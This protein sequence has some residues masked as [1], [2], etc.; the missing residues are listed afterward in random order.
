MA[1]PSST[2]ILNVGRLNAFRLNALAAGLRRTRNQ[3]LTI[4]LNGVPVRVRLGSLTIHDVIN[5]A[6]NTA[7]LT[8]DNATPPHVGDRLE[9]WQGVEPKY[10]LFA[11]PIQS[12]V[13]DY[14]GR[15]AV[16]EWHC[17]AVD[18]THR[19]EW[20]RPFGAWENVTATQVAI[21]LVNQF[22]PGFTWTGV[23]LGLPPVTLYLDGTERIG[24]ALRLMAK[25]IGGYFYWENKDLH[26]FQGDEP[27]LNPDD[28]TGAPGQLLDDPPF[29]WSNDDSQIRTRCYGK[30]HGEPTLAAVDAGATTI[31]IANAV[32]FNVAGGSAISEWQRL[33]Y[34]GTAPGGAGALVGPGVVPTAAPT[35]A[36][37]A[38]SGVD[39]G[40]HYYAY[41]WYTGA[42]A[43]GT[44]ETL[45]SPIAS[46]VVVGG[47]IGAPTAANFSV[48]SGVQF[49]GPPAGTVMDYMFYI[50]DNGANFSPPAYGTPLRITSTGNRPQ[51][52]FVTTADMRGRYVW[53]YRNDNNG[54]GWANTS[55]QGINVPGYA[56]PFP[57]NQPTGYPQQWTEI[58]TGFTGGLGSPPAGGNLFLPT[59]VQLTGIAVGPPGTLYRRIY[60]S[61]ANTSQLR[62]IDGFAD[63]TSTSYL[64]QR[65]DSL[66]TFNAPTTDTSG[67]QMPAG[68]VLPGATALP[69]SST[70][71][72]RAAGGWAVVGNGEQ[73]IRYGGVTGNQ[74][75]GIP[76][77]GNGAI[78]APVNYNST[79][80]GAPMVTGIPASGTG[81][82]AAPGLR[83]GAP[84]N[85]WVQYDDAT[86]Q[87][88]LGARVG[89]SGIIENL[90]VDERRGEASLRSLCLA[91]VAMYGYAI[92][93]ARYTCF[94]PKSKSGRPIKINLPGVG[95]TGQ[96]LVIQDVSITTGSDP[97]RFTVQASSVRASFEDLLRRLTGT[98][99]EGF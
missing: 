8:V 68:Q 76:A 51:I 59:A 26:F 72:A 23:Q 20:Q 49:G 94:D 73:V 2:A 33:T 32:M 42:G 86:A 44:G 29:A 77:A 88:N 11:G 7:T 12:A 53:V 95:I 6:P 3:K 93:Q 16:L 96:I 74:L 63:N 82:I 70:G 31:P 65:A 39:V 57:P 25:L 13:Q 69:V 60:R 67:L 52:N 17:Q 21:D 98:L 56:V 55:M 80:S 35:A 24:G 54:Q 22:C 5:D 85:I 90:I 87:A 9:V 37:A 18:D 79:I 66:L 58:T 71:W 61:A 14:V 4:T 81:S 40:G 46:V 64:D 10:L 62:F 34:T 47:A 92:T 43:G 19:S 99:E 27:G 1:V 83:D 50:S 48:S 75:T 41:T 30:G 78:A 15:P 84:V 36:I 38:G 97:P 28:L 91:D 45:P 89:G